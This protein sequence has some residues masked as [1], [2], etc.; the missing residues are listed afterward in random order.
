MESKVM[1]TRFFPR[2]FYLFG[3]N[4][5]SGFSIIHSQNQDLI[6]KL[7]APIPPYW[8]MLFLLHYKFDYVWKLPRPLLH[9]IMVHRQR[10]LTTWKPFI[11]TKNLSVFGTAPV[12]ISIWDCTFVY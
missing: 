1:A 4:F 8:S 2:S 6:T 11:L 12:C 10:T 3:L 7:S 5:L 9:Q